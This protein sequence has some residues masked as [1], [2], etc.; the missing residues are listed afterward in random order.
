MMTGL[1]R[2]G[3]VCQRADW[4]QAARA[5]LRFIQLERWIDDGRTS[6]RLLALPG[7]DAFLDDHAFLLEA[8]LALHAADPQADDLPFAEA[9]AKAMLAQ[10][11]DRDEG[12][13]Y[14]TRHDSR[15]LIHRLKSGLDAATPS[16][17]G[18]AALALLALA[19]QLDAAQAAN[20]RTAAARCVRAFAATVRS[21]PASH[22][23]LLQAAARL[24]AASQVLANANISG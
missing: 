6:G 24:Q 5:A 3:A 15:A 12:G 2:A 21:D 17:N 18:T 8:V 13:F 7:Q 20:Y 4:L 1:A 11:E 16:G 10:F 19:E 9:I 14:F 23:R 22:T